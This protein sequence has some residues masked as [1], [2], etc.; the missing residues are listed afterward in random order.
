MSIFDYYQKNNTVTDL[1]SV[2]TLDAGLIDDT[3][4]VQQAV[5]NG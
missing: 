5:S 3:A 2:Y 1:H 4:I